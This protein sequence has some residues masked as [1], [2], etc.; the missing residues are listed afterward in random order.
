MEISKNIK[1]PVQDADTNTNSKQ[2]P[3]PNNDIY[4]SID[5]RFPPSGMGQII[6]ESQPKE[7]PFE[8]HDFNHTVYNYTL[9]TYHDCGYTRNPDPFYKETVTIPFNEQMMDG[10]IGETGF[11][12]LENLLKERGVSMV[13]DSE[14]SYEIPGYENSDGMIELEVWLNY[15]SSC[16]GIER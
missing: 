14:A 13:Y 11:R 9:V 8:E 5:Y 6:D 7:I 4:F 12:F 3:E 16:F 15:L 1:S 10:W 2:Y